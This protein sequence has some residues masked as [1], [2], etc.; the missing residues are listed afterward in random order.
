MAKPTA[1][2]VAAPKGGELARP[3]FMQGKGR[4]SENVGFEDLTIPRLDLIQDLS[5]QRKKTEPEYIEG[6]EE[7][8]MFNS[9]SKKLYGDNVT[10]IPVY[11][12]KEYVIWKD[13]KKGGGFKGA[14]PTPEAAEAGMHD[15]DLNPEDHDIIDTAQHFGLLVDDHTSDKPVI[16]EIVLSLSK[17]KMK[18]NRQINTLARMAGGDRFERGYRLSSFTDENSNGDKFFNFKVTQLGFVSEAVFRAAEKVYESV[19]SGTKDVV[20]DGQ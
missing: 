12:R 20:R 18:A 5:P 15:Q 7:G 13:R 10:F 19:V 4:G 3:A 14:Y 1:Q 17:S 11:F 9:V 6:A 8:M 2:E 16:E